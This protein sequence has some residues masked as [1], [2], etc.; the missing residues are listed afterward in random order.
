MDD[1]SS[2]E[3]VQIR[4][5]NELGELELE[6]EGRIAMRPY[7]RIAGVSDTLPIIPNDRRDACPTI[8][9]SQ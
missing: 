5:F 4:F 1:A 8:H 9:S 6:P 2:E 7:T 3:G